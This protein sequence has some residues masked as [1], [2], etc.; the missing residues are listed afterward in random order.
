MWGI[1]TIECWEC[2]KIRKLYGW[3]PTTRQ[4][5]AQ[6]EGLLCCGVQTKLVNFEEGEENEH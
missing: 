6:N 2:D 1:T 3:L 5:W 4:I